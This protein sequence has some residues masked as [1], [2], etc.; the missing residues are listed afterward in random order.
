VEYFQ[1]ASVRVSS[2]EPVPVEVDGDVIG[3]LPVSFKLMPRA[4][5]VLVPRPAG[6]AR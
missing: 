5:N 3:T 6:S 4:L 2:T 1:T